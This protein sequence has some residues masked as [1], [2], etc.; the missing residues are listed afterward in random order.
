MTDTLSAA[1]ARRIFLSAQGLAR[2]RSPRRVGDA[3]FAEY[4]RRQGVLQ[5]D[6]VNVLARAHYMPLFSRYGA[7]DRA[8][9]DSFLWGDADGHSPHAFEHWG[10][11]ASVSPLAL[12]PAMHVKMTDTGA[13]G[14]RNEARIEAA[15]PGLI[16]QVR[17]RVEAAG[18]FDAAGL[19]HIAPRLEASGPWWDHSA[20]KSAL[21]H[22]FITGKVA[23]SRRGHFRR[24]YDSTMRGWG[25]APADVGTWG[26]APDAAR[27]ALFDHAVSAVGIGTPRDVADHFR[28]K[29][30]LAKGLAAD[31]VAR[32]VADWVDVEGWG[33]RALLAA[34]A[35]DPGR[36]TGAALLS[37]FDPVC[38][39]RPRLERMFGM[40]YRIEIY[41]PEPKRVYGYYTLPFLL[42]DQVV[43]RFDLKA[44]RGART[45]RVLASWR[46]E[47]T[48]PG[49]RRR[50]NPEI[51]DAV[52][53]ELGAM[54]TWLGLETIRVESR[55]N[56]AEAVAA[57]LS[58]SAT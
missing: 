32:G 21:E 24:T 31:A 9:L 2:K 13:W 46:E 44:D 4:L 54:A 55:G 17:E 41:T 34:G 11:E 16:A 27:Q 20:V 15:H 8:T 28:L 23:A 5:L 1:A 10:H 58:E 19:E 37:P 35:S 6:S 39:Y 12:L 25:V 3:Q 33:D 53:A 49:A 40:T 29:P 50:G 42:G 7:Y 18:P 30:G 51:A 14:S 22:L 26:L 52:A 48:V 47:R 45:L 57:S 56:L 36:A 38:W 43:G